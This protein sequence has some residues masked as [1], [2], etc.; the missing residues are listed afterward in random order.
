[1][2]SIDILKEDE[3]RKIKEEIKNKKELK[4]EC[5]SLNINYEMFDELIEES[6]QIKQKDED[7][8]LAI[9]MDNH[10]FFQSL[11]PKQAASENLWATLNIFY[12]DTYVKNRWLNSNPSEKQIEARV[13][14]AGKSL[15]NR[16][17]MARLWWITKQSKDST[18]EDPYLYTRILLSRMQFEQSIMEST[19]AKSSDIL[20]KLM[21]AI[22]K[23]ES[24]N[25]IISSSEIKKVMKRLNLL[26]G[27]YV[28]DIMD[29]DYFYNVIKNELN[30]DETAQTIFQGIDD[31]D[32]IINI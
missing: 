6:E 30:R 3:V 31:R 14:K 20:K 26:G 5:P 8:N 10:E 17:A 7:I 16:N 29:S 1:M 15:F 9:K 18:Q 25:E 21:S 4:V 24:E 28:L 23:F 27:T 32:D 2:I 22:V 11:T 19:L 13:F 12:F